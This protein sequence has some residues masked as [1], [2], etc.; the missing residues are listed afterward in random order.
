V[1]GLGTRKNAVVQLGEKGNDNPHGSTREL[2][3]SDRHPT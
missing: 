2:D 3:C 1:P